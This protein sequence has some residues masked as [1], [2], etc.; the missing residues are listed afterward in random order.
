MC[1]LAEIYRMKRIVI[2]LLLSVPIC[3]SAQLTESFKELREFSI[4]QPPFPI[5]TAPFLSVYYNKQLNYLSGYYK[6]FQQENSLLRSM[7][8]AAYYDD[9]TQTMAFAGDYSSLLA[10]ERKKYDPLPDS[11]EEQA[12][13]Q[14]EL[15]KKA[16]Y[17]DARTYIL[18]RTKN[19]KVVMINEANDKPLHRAF[20]ASLLEDLFR[21]GYH[22]LAM[23]TLNNHKNTS[24]RKLNMLTGHYT[25]EPVGGELVRKALDIGFT[26]VPYEENAADATPNEREYAQA[27]NIY[28]ILKKDTAA[29]IIVHAGYGHIE[30]GA[31]SDSSI[32]MASYFKII[33]GINPLTI[34]QTEMTENSTSSYGAWIY[35]LWMQKHPATGSVVPLINDKPVDPYDLNLNDIYVIHP[36]TK[37]TN[38]RPQWMTMNG[39]KKEVPVQPAYKFS[40]LVQAYYENEYSDKTAGLAVPADQTYNTGSDGYY[41]LYLHKG[42]YQI[43][44]RD[45]YYK[46]IG[47]KVINIE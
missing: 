7:G 6:A 37:F 15:C 18:N 38:A 4:K 21:Q 19:N 35:D 13:L 3:C 1:I 14:T 44:F 12:V 5:D 34:D 33:S 41:Y 2:L 10:L 27:A 40:F 47:T 36:P 31:K 42:K 29:K 8:T 9:L 43:V 26:L 23:E 20:T 30:E 39:W 46:I 25:C 32:M 17:T 22:Y 11:L 45:K 16:F 28:A 24:L